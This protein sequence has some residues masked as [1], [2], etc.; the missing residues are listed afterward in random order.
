M[1]ILFILKTVLESGAKTSNL[2]SANETVTGPWSTLTKYFNEFF[3]LVTFVLSLSPFKALF[4][5]E[6]LLMVFSISLNDKSSDKIFH[7]TGLSLSL[8][9]RISAKSTLL[10]T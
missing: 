1:Q 10:I 7:S 9:K 6:I 8:L 5:S 3:K 2:F 4:I